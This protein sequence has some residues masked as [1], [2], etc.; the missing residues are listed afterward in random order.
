MSTS[1]SI[2]CGARPVER[3]GYASNDALYR[4]FGFELVERYNANPVPGI[5]FYRLKLD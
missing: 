4:S 2:C 1:R 5:V 3:D